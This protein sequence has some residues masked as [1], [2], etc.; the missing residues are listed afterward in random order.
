ME[1]DQQMEI[2]NFI[3]NASNEELLKLISVAFESKE[4]DLFRHVLNELV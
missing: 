4:D 1:V 3:L 2:K